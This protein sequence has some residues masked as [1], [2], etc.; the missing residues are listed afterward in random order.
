[1]AVLPCLLCGDGLKQRTDKNG[2][3]YFVCD[4]CGMQMFIRR[5]KGHENLTLLFEALRKTGLPIRQHAVVLYKIRAILQ[6]IDGVE[7]EIKKL[8][9]ALKVFSKNKVRKRTQELL[10]K[11]IE[12]LLLE[13]KQIS[14][15]AK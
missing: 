2:K 5:K 8:N 13:L 15:K 11:R 14:E 1:M 6:E 10:R 9:G 3:P 7:C 12:T 4:P